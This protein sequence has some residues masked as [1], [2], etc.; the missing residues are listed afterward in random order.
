MKPEVITVEAT[1]LRGFQTPFRPK[2]MPKDISLAKCRKCAHNKN[3]CT[4][5]DLM[6][7]AYVARQSGLK[8][9]R[10]FFCAA[11]S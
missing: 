8:R 7:C 1:D 3:G 2:R 6:P 4:L 5:D 9:I 10:S 11:K